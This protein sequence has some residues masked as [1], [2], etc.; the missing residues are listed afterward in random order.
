MIDDLFTIDKLGVTLFD[1]YSLKNKFLQG[2]DANELEQLLDGLPEN[3]QKDIVASY[4][5]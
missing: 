4:F 2:D 1:P 5:E 3:V